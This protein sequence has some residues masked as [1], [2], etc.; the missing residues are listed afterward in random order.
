MSINLWRV[1]IFCTQNLIREVMTHMLIISTIPRLENEEIKRG[2]D[3]KSDFMDAT[4]AQW[5]RGMEESAFLE[6]REE[7]QLTPTSWF[8]AFACS[9]SRVFFR[10]GHFGKVSTY[11]GAREHCFKKKDILPGNIPR[12]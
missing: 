11:V 9:K 10:W 1:L 6:C 4:L 2:G 7:I 3:P 12:K 8:S 5:G